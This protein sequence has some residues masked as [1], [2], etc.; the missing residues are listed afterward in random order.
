M[1]EIICHNDECIDVDGWVDNLRW[2]R[3]VIEAHHWETGHG[4]EVVNT[5]GARIFCQQGV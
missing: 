5:T 4:G 2:A 1:F 3:E